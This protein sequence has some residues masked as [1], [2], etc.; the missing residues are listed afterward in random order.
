MRHDETALGGNKKTEWYWT[1][2]LVKR[3]FNV[4][5][6]TND[7]SLQEHQQRKEAEKQRQWQA[8]SW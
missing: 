4:G 7:K 5:P 3:G 8:A 6:Y 2:K 1:G